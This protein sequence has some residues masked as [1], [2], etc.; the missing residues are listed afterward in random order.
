[1]AT[2][3]ESVWYVAYGSNLSA[4]RFGCYIAGGQPT[5]A[6]RQYPGCRDRSDVRATASLCLPGG[7]F[8]AGRSLTWGGG[9][10][11]YD[12]TL[13]GRA[14]VRAYLLTPGQFAD[15]AAQ[16]MHRVPDA[17]LD[18]GP[19]LEGE[20]HSWGQGRYETVL[21]VGTRDGHPMLTF[22]APWG[23][24]GVT[25]AAPSAAYLRVIGAGLAEA[26]GWSARQIAGYLAAAPGAR[27]S[28]SPEGVLWVLSRAGAAPRTT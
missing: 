5:G 24:G 16:E 9:M 18:L 14:A 1:L 27:D 7:L 13:P 8:F 21:R 20:R 12:P 19:L 10:A 2:P 6:T 23:A 25:T 3:P 26:H 4:A 15:V 28:W 17:D 11:F 22:T